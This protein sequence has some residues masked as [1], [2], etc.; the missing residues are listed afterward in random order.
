VRFDF[1]D[2]LGTRWDD[3]VFGLPFGLGVKYRHSDRMAFRL[4]VADNVAFPGAAMETMHVLSVTG[5]AEIRFGG[6]RRAY[7]PWNPGRHYW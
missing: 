1:S 3:T 4:E 6:S 2:R 5:G 7:W